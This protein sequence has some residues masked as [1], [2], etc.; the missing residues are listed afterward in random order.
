M[1]RRSLSADER[2][3]IVGEAEQEEMID[4]LEIWQEV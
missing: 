4:G 3:K 1:V 2:W